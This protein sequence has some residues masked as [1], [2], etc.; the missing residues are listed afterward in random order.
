MAI[1]LYFG[2]PGCGKTTIMTKL[3]LDAVKSK[4]YNNVYCNVPIAVPGVTYID[5]SCIGRYNL[6]NGLILIDE[7]TIFADSRDHKNF[8]KQKIEYFL[9]HRHFNVDVSLFCQQ[10]DAV[11][12]KIRTITDRVFYVY[13]GFFTGHWIT[14]YYRIPYGIIIPEK[15]KT[16]GEK[17]GD[18]IQG[19]C[20]PNLL[21]RM[22]AR[23]V[24]RP[25][26]YKYFDSWE[27]PYRDPLPAKYQ[28][29]TNLQFE[30]L[31]RQRRE[32]RQRNKRNILLRS[33]EALTRPFK[34]AW[35][36][37]RQHFPAALSRT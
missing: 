6:E 9:L 30:E 33:R 23:R 7:A 8:D 10:W 16:S 15:G 3:A 12:K 22:F 11:D 28:M 20:K 37:I 24:F 32:E 14:K 21:V 1:S 26:Y 18:I 13:K 34:Q 2:L 17:L 25:K 5:N 31:E 36:W 4:R 29:Y 19:Y 27:R 35:A